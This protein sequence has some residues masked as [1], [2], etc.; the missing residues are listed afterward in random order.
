MTKLTVKAFSGARDFNIYRFA[1]QYDPSTEAFQYADRL[2]E[3]RM[4]DT[5]EIMVDVEKDGKI[6]YDAE[7]FDQ[8][9]NRWP[10][11]SWEDDAHMC[12]LCRVSGVTMSPRG[13][14]GNRFMWVTHRNGKALPRGGT[15]MRCIHKNKEKPEQFDW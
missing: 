15:W 5:M 4:G 14:I 10:L 2:A 11:E 1:T 12:P 13:K 6:S 8:I 7:D 9:L 3:D